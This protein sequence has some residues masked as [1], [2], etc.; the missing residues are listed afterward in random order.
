MCVHF[1]KLDKQAT[2]RHGQI[3]IIPEMDKSPL[4]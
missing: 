1:V 4:G 2:G 3:D